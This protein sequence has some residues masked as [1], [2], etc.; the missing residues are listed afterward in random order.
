MN[1]IKGFFIITLIIGIILIALYFILD[2]KEE[3][4]QHIIYKYIPR[5]LEEENES[6]IYVSEIFK[7]MFCSFDLLKLYTCIDNYKCT[8]S[9]INRNC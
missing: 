4:K 7:N 9:R 2:N 8:I 5:T 6:P 1:I 3:S